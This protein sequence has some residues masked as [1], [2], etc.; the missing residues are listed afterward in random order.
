MQIP[1]NGSAPLLVGVQVFVSNVFNVVSVLR[2]RNWRD[3]SAELGM[4]IG[5]DSAPAVLGSPTFFCHVAPTPQVTHCPLPQDILRYTMSS[6]LLLRLVSPT[7]R[8]GGAKGTKVGQENWLSPA[9]KY[10][11]SST[12]SPNRE[13]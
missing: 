7:G 6:M 2:P 13:R 10:W 8:G 4:G 3:P 12:Y 9:Q 1:N 5:Q 11:P